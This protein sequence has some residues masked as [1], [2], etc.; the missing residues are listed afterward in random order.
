MNGYVD[1]MDYLTKCAPFNRI[2][3]IRKPTMFLNAVNDP[4]MGP[5]VID[6]D[7]F[8]LNPNAVLATNQ[9]AGH[10]G[11]HESLLSLDQWFAKPCLD[12][13]DAV[14][15]PSDQEQE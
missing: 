5:D 15:A 4:F 7:V 9:Y 1:G 6:Y 14:R 11:Y 3:F 13:L 8:K 2:P 10:M 12:F